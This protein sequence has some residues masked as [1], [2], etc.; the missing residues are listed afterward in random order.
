MNT[1]RF[2]N[3][4]WVLVLG[5]I[6]VMFGVGGAMHLYGGDRHVPAL[7][8]QA[9][10]SD[11]AN[12]PHPSFDKVKQVYIY[13]KYTS[14]IKEEELPASLRRKNLEELLLRLYTERFSSKDCHKYLKGKNPYS[15]DDLP[16]ILVPIEESTHFVLGMNTSFATA[17]KRKK[18]S[19]LNVILKVSIQGKEIAS[20][21]PIQNSLATLYI[22]HH[23]P[24]A[25]DL[26]ALGASFPKS[27]P[28]N[29]DEKVIEKGL[30][31]FVK[32]QIH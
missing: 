6:V 27:F 13:V 21:P 8:T 32:G 29:Q 10:A 11:Y 2:K 23:R 31:L 7:V 19:T 12:W 5:I 16:V 24:Q 4:K 3:K 30:Y 20:I 17:K 26:P 1:L 28:I 22:M 18:P 15:C 14:T 25:K 9:Q